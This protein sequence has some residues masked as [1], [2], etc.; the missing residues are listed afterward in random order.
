MNEE[1]CERVTVD[2]APNPPL[3]DQ[4]AHGLRHSS[5]RGG[6][7]SCKRHHVTTTQRVGINNLWPDATRQTRAPETGTQSNNVAAGG[8]SC[9]R[10]TYL[11]C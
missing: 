4:Q 5:K 2:R 6:P 3:P 11:P 7:L 8:C 10:H 9:A 1:A